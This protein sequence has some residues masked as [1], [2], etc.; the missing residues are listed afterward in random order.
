MDIC[1]ICNQDIEGYGHNAQPVKDGRCCD[2]C[3]ST[4]VIPARLNPNPVYIHC[5]YNLEKKVFDLN[6]NLDGNR[7]VELHLNPAQYMSLV[8]YLGKVAL[9]FAQSDEGKEWKDRV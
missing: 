1:V 6:F 7:H 8:E 4:V 3:N 2:V 9:S 5:T